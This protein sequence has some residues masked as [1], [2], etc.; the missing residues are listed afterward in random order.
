MPG[1]Q[2]KG[3]EKWVDVEKLNNGPTAIGTNISR[4]VDR[5]KATKTVV[6]PPQ[7]SEKNKF[8]RGFL[9]FLFTDYNISLNNSGRSVFIDTE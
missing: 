6:V 1:N 5:I 3:R 8:Y 4:R 7:D 9:P 2:C